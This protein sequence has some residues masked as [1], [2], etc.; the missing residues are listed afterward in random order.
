MTS[1]PE[2]EIVRLELAFDRFE[3]QVVAA[4]CTDAGLT[5]ELLLM[6]ES[7]NVPGLNALTPHYLLARLDEL[8]EVHEILARK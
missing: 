8:E 5:V 4:A 3:A 6:D 7:G 1:K 2:S